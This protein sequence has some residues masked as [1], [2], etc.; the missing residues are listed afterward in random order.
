M[1]VS[2]IDFGLNLK[3]V[4]WGHIKMKQH[5]TVFCFKRQWSLEDISSLRVFVATR[6]GLK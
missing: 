1:S 6:T 2:H 5:V 3:D 4:I